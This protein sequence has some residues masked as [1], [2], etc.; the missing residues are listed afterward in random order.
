MLFFLVGL[1]CLARGVCPWRLDQILKTYSVFAHL[2]ESRLT[3]FCPPPS[4]LILLRRGLRCCH[5]GARPWTSSPAMTN[6]SQR[7]FPSIRLGLNPRRVD[8]NAAI[9][10]VNLN[11]LIS[12]IDY[13]PWMRLLRG[14]NVDKMCAR[15]PIQKDMLQRAVEVHLVAIQAN[16]VS[17]SDHGERR[18]NAIASWK[19][20]V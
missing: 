11:N 5:Y 16:R 13:S 1:T 6:L 4:G 20:S 14:R 18:L 19:V 9:K 12:L 8:L 7:C 17:F 15:T 10:E 2:S 3:K